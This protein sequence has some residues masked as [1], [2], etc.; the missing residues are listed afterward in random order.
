MTRQ[1]LIGNLEKENIASAA[2]MESLLNTHLWFTFI[3]VFS[4]KFNVSLPETD[5][6]PQIPEGI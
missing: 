2:R 4:D 1:N 3:P 6:C 5:K